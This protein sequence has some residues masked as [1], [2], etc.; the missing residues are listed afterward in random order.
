M[1]DYNNIKFKSFSKFSLNKIIKVN[2]IN[3]FLCLFLIYII[4]S[5]K[6]SFLHVEFLLLF[7][8]P[9]YFAFITISLCAIIPLV[10]KPFEKFIDNIKL[11]ITLIIFNVIVS[12]FYFSFT[13]N[14]SVSFIYLVLSNGA[15]VTSVAIRHSNIKINQIKGKVN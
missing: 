8:G 7:L 4:V 3:S 14:L 5:N 12:I 13:E 6:I 1:K 15:I 9:F 11:F 10:I 2:I